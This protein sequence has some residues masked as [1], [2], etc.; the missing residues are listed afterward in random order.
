MLDPEQPLQLWR[1]SDGKPGHDNQSRGLC[2]ALASRVPVDIHEIDVCGKRPGLLDL[3][4]R[5]FPAGQQLS[6]PDLIIAAGHATHLPLLAARRARGGRCIVLMK[7][8]L[9]LRLFDLCLIPEHDGVT[10]S[11]NVLLTRGA[12][13]TIAPGHDTDAGSGLILVGGPSAH[14]DWQEDELL[15]GLESILERDTDITWRITDSRRTPPSTREKL[16]QLADRK[17]SLDFTDAEHTAPG[18][19]ARQLGEAGRVWVTS[20]SVSMIY[21]ALTAGAATGILE[22]PVR[23][24]DRI[25][26]SIDGLIRQQLLTRFTDWQAGKPLSQNEEKLAEAKR[27]A[28]DIVRRWFSPQTA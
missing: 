3:L 25:T 12:L 18:W 11:E 28:D 10:A 4:F 21:E 13:N 7:P 14:H 26:R 22:M 27:C 5:R 20:D 23:K 8:S 19:V 24:A 2:L 9:P 6:D 17:A 1:L 15:A 16:R